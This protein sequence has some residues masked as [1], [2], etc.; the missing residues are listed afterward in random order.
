VRAPSPTNNAAERAVGKAV[1][2]R[3]NSFGSASR[4][5]SRFAERMLTAC[6]S[7][8]AQGRSTLDFLDA[9]IR[10]R[11]GG[12]AHRSLLPSPHSR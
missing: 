7:L 2:W 10:I 6:E 8:Q 1:L 9:S 3:K 5:G 4:W 12:T 11:V